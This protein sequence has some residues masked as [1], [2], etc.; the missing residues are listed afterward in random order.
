MES[1]SD[2]M[3]ALMRKGVGRETL[4]AVNR[5]FHEAGVATAWMTFTDHPGESPEE[6][7]E[8]VRWIESELDHVDLFVVGEFGLES[9]SDVAR[10][11]ERYGVSR[12][13]YAAGDDFRLHA[14]FLEGSGKRA[15]ADRERIDAMVR[16]LA[17]RFSLR[18]YPWAGAVSTHH[19]FLHFLELGPRVFLR[20]FQR[21]APQD[22][23]PLESPRPAHIPGL[24]ERERFSVDA[25][26]RREK[27]FF[28]AY[29]PTALLP[30]DGEDAGGVGV[31]PL[32][33]GHFR[34]A[35][36]G[37]EPLRAGSKAGRRAEARRGRRSRRSS[38]TSRDAEL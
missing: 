19:S 7:L 25:I 22:R 37:V 32:S 6:A 27:E 26:V 12:I 13:Y 33:A 20:H 31:A 34:A 21:A 38:G 28:E 17:S 8:T 35:V 18:P 11:P 30:R 29:L 16:R 36:A 24:R 1:G 3:L 23:A 10:H 2:R 15:E 4:T 5:T 14:L 9:G